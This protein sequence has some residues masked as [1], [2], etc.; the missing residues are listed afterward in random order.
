MLDALR[1]AKVVE[2]FRAAVVVHLVEISPTLQ[3]LQEQRLGDLEIPI[4]W[5][6]ALEEVPTGPSIILANEFIDALPIHQAVKQRDG[7]HERVIDVDG[8]G[9][10]VF[11]VAPKPLPFFDATVP[12]RLR[13][14]PD[15]AIFEWRSD[16]AALE[17]GRRVRTGGA[18][19]VLDYGYSQSSVGDTLQAVS[20]HSFTNPLASP[21]QVDLTAHVDFEALA[22]SAESIGGRVFGPVAQ[23]DFLLRLGI[24]KRAAALKA[25]VPQERAVE[26]DV[27]LSRLIG[28]GMRGMGELF[29]A[30]AICDRKIGPPPGFEE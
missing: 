9:G 10:F 8:E 2:G 1:A 28:G 25:G 18:A 14:A 30:L 21:G 19:L 7:W 22:E 12:R 15:G 23:R 29:K 13:Q 11:G 17:V 5:H 26:I 16:N 4:M 27:A 20:G 6:A 24:D 3:R